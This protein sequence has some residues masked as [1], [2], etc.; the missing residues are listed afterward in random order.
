MFAPIKPSASSSFGY[1]C[2]VN[3]FCPLF[4]EEEE[5]ED[6]V[7]D[8]SGFYEDSVFVPATRMAIERSEKVKIDESSKCVVC[9]EEIG[10]VYEA[11]R[12]PCSHVFHGNC[13]VDWLG[14]TNGCPVCRFNFLI[15]MWS[16]SVSNHVAH[17]SADSAESEST[18]YPSQHLKPIQSA[19][20]QLPG[21]LPIQSAFHIGNSTQSAAHVLS[22]WADLHVSIPHV[23][24]FQVSRR[25]LVHVP[26]QSAIH[27]I[28]SQ[29]T[30]TRYH[31][32]I[33]CQASIP[34]V[35][36][37]PVSIHTFTMSAPQS[38]QHS[39][40]ASLQVSRTCCTR[41]HPTC[42]L[43]NPVSI[44]HQQIRPVSRTCVVHVC[45]LIHVSI[46][47][48]GARP[49]SS[50]VESRS[51][52]QS[53]QRST[54]ASSV[55]SRGHVLPRRHSKLSQ[56]QNPVSSPRLHI[57]PPQQTRFVHVDIRSHI[58]IPA[59]HSD[60]P[61]VQVSKAIQSAVRGHVQS[62]HRHTCCLIVMVS[63]VSLVIPT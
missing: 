62:S 24:A 27:G 29:V 60:P 20:T 26:I 16:G 39:T 4:Q 15:S 13:I 58:I 1:D 57:Q 61:G 53:S 6:D 56:R 34:P 7:D 18:C 46:P 5:E 52:L 47:R 8:E 49:V 3:L 11:T 42:Q 41:Q 37:S 33:V 40:S 32:G 31:V 25:V 10:L 17:M 21:Q 19:S 44:P 35:L 28:F 63:Q 23:W 9:L 55:Y 54:G 45:R 38:S 51:A 43:F 22:T 48:V 50:H 2:L 30:R 59:F 36:C 14:Q 12:M